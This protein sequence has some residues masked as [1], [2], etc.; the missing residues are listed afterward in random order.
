MAWAV[1]QNPFVVDPATAK[2]Q[3]EAEKKF[4]ER[5]ANVREFS[6]PDFDS[7]LVEE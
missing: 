7:Q 5:L 3:D 2:E 1:G 4:T 6:E